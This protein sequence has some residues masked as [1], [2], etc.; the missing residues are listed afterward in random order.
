[1]SKL[2][3]K[4]QSGIKF[5]RSKRYTSKNGQQ[6]GSGVWYRDTNKNGHYDPGEPLI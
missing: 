2:I 3:K 4:A 1:M 5:D 6:R